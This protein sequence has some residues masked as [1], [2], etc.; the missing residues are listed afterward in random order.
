MKNKD[1]EKLCRRAWDWDC[2]EFDL[3][4]NGCAEAAKRTVE[5]LR[6][7][8]ESSIMFQ[9]LICL[10]HRAHADEN[11]EMEASI[12]RTAG[13]LALCHTEEMERQS[14]GL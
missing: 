9:T 1:W 7:E 14:K 10:C 8:A 3:T 6:S 11:H 13:F 2:R 12:R 4:K 5:T